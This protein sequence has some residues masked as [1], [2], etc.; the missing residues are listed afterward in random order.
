MQVRMLSW[1]LVGCHSGLVG[2]VATWHSTRVGFLV[3]VDN[4]LLKEDACS[5]CGVWRVL[6]KV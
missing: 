4:L 6:S 1:L 5:V 2:R 3:R